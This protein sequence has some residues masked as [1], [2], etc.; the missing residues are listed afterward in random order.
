[1]KQTVNLLLTSLSS[2][3]DRK[4]HRYFYYNKDGNLLYCD[5][6]SVAEAGAKYI[7]ADV[8]I[9]EII[10]LGTGN[11][12]EPGEENKRIILRE[13]SDFTSMDTKEISEYSFFQYRISQFLDGLD[14]E[15]IDVL[16]DTE[17]VRAE[18]ILEGYNKFCEELSA[19]PTYRPDRV[20]HMISSDENLYNHLLSLLPALSDKEMLWLERYIYTQFTDKM[21]L[22][23]REDNTDIG[24]SFIPTSHKNS[25]NYVPAEN[26]A[27]IVRQLNAVD[28][29]RVNVYMDMQGLA[30]AEGYTIL[31]V[32]SM[33]SNDQNSRIF[34][35]EI[36][37][38][39]YRKGRFANPI[40]NNEMK[41]YEINNLV[42]GMSAFISYGKVD[43]I[44]AYWDSRGIEN[45][46]V[47][48]LLYAMRR[49]D[50][51]ISLCNTGDLESGI[52]MLKDVFS[53][54]PREELPEVESNIFRILEDT[55]RGDYGK[56]LEGD[57]VDPLELVRWAMK[58]KFYQQ[59]LTIIESRL[60]QN[61]VDSGIF[62]YADSPE[63]R[64]SFLEEV[65]L[66]YWDSA[67]KDRWVF[68]DMAHY[69]MKYYGRNQMR[70]ARKSFNSSDRQ[71]D[72]TKY[73]V[74]QLEGKAE[75]MKNAYSVLREDRELVED[76]LYTYYHL[77]DIRNMINHAQVTQAE[78]I[79]KIDIHKENEN[80]EMLRT[81][82]EA[83][84]N[85]YDAAR[86]YMAEHNIG[87][88]ETYQISKQE[89]KAYTSAHKLY[90]NEIR[91]IRN[92][93]KAEEKKPADKPAEAAKPAGNAETAKPSDTA[94][95]VK[96]EKPADNAADAEKAVPAA[97]GSEVKTAA[98]TGG[99][100]APN[101]NSS[102]HGSNRSGGYNS[103]NR[104]GYGGQNRN[105]GY[106]NQNRSGFSRDKN[107]QS[108]R[109]GNGNRNVTITVTV[110]E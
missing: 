97:A 27:E 9:D 77:G 64:E 14:M 56:L 6:L 66:L 46:H 81:G 90:P 21:K 79:R 41:R 20:F 18:E 88:V 19:Q 35:E 40:D 12:Y 13:W 80:V 96:T 110:D 92:G 31:A 72:F 37:T 57:D 30:S 95:D 82:I 59:S 87:S 10:V 44:Q 63:A 109:V 103:Q 106:N 23:R 45:P 89:V 76:V 61:I 24:I 39:H 86:A 101:R 70:N 60:P 47:E 32:L 16:E 67:P 102:Y 5:G 29:E 15:A 65:N 43:E 100:S 54:T 78:D 8:D 107:T 2:L 69:F 84:V 25:E 49:V 7:L 83:F 4:W 99:S 11:T 104:G 105:G 91:E 71:R 17:G 53:S 34:I 85:A 50:E 26:V 62:Y 94:A 75:L 28:A 51:G 93:G 55:I 1:M 98:P 58:K 42:S 38:S 108:I 48:M 36:I 33:L 73:R 74:D 68:D 22:S 3:D 52:D